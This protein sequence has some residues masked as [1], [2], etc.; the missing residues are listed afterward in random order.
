MDTHAQ[1]PAL[2]RAPATQQGAVALD[3]MLDINEVV[4]VTK[5]GK[6]AWY[7]AIKNKKAP[8]PYRVGAR[9]VAWKSSEIQAHLNSL[10]RVDLADGDAA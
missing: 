6:S 2:L 3:P 10:P 9:R 8:A 7:A 4:A 5:M 1:I